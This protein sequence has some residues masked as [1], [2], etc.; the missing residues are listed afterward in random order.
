MLPQANS[1]N[2]SRIPECNN[3]QSTNTNDTE[4]EESKTGMTRFM[5]TFS[6]S[7]KPKPT[8]LS[9]AQLIEQ[10]KKEILDLNK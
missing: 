2:I 8:K 5:D 10:K 3:D 4:V 6:N 9:M 1:Q 7:V